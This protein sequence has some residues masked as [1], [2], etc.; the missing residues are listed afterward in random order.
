MMTYHVQHLDP[1][2]KGQ[3]HIWKSKPK[4][5]CY[6]VWCQVRAKQIRCHWWIAH[7]PWLMTGQE[8][9]PVTDHIIT[10]KYWKQVYKCIYV[11]PYTGCYFIIF[12]LW[13]P[14]NLNLALIKIW[15][16]MSKPHTS[17]FWNSTLLCF[18]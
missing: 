14:C 13:I 1:Y 18:M 10:L 17:I 5:V 16:W 2:L 12:L 8:I 15:H 4:L 9:Y 6:S 3:G 7:I 11:Y